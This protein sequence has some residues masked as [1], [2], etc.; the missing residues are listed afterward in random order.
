MKMSNNKINLS[1]EQQI[2]QF[3]SA[4]R[5]LLPL[6]S[7]KSEYANMTDT[8]RLFN[9][10]DT[11]CVSATDRCIIAS[12]PI[13]NISFEDN[14]YLPKDVCR[15]II[16]RYKDISYLEIK[17]DDDKVRVSGNNFILDFESNRYKEARYPDLT[18]VV[19]SHFEAI[20]KCSLETP[21]FFDRNDLLTKL[22]NLSKYLDKPYTDVFITYK[23]DF[24]V[25]IPGKEIEVLYKNTDMFIHNILRANLKDFIRLLNHFKGEKYLYLHVTNA[26]PLFIFSDKK[27]YNY[28]EFFKMHFGILNI[29]VEEEIYS[30]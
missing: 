3:V 19:N 24:R 10:K 12:Y 15:E 14:F 23:N 9:Y 16:K 18:T 13:G 28:D 26:F 8:I 5:N 21:W 22:K 11:L 30:Y 27:Y 20:N 6:C 29:I 7:R 2:K 1:G 4:I 25:K 17:K